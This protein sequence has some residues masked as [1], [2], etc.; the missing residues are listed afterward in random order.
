MEDEFGAFPAASCAAGD[1]A[2]RDFDAFAGGEAENAFGGRGG[3]CGEGAEKAVDLTGHGDSAGAFEGVYDAWGDAVGP[4]A[5]WQA[6][7]AEEHAACA[8]KACEPQLRGEELTSQQ[9]AVGPVAGEVGGGEVVNAGHES[10]NGVGQQAAPEPP[11]HAHAEWHPGAEGTP[12]HETPCSSQNE[13]SFCK[14]Q[15]SRTGENAGSL[16]GV[17]C[18]VAPPRWLDDTLP[19]ELVLQ[20]EEGIHAHGVLGE[21]GQAEECVAQVEHA[22]AEA[23]AGVPQLFDADLSTHAFWGGGAVGE[24]E[25]RQIGGGR[26]VLEDGDLDSVVHHHHL[27]SVVHSHLH[28]PA[29]GEAAVVQNALGAHEPV[30]EMSNAGGE[31]P[32]QCHAPGFGEPRAHGGEGGGGGEPEALCQCASVACVEG[33]DEEKRSSGPRVLHEPGNETGGFGDLFDDFAPKH[34]FPAHASSPL[35]VPPEAHARDVCAC[36]EQAEGVGVQ[37]RLASAET[38]T[39]TEAETETETET[40]TCFL[41]SAETETGGPPATQGDT[42]TGAGNDTFDAFGDDAFGDSDAL[43]THA[44][45]DME[46][47]YQAL[48]HTSHTRH[49]LGNTDDA[50]AHVGDVFGGTGDGFA[51]PRLASQ[52]GN[53]VLA[54]THDVLALAADAFGDVK[55]VNGHHV[56]AVNAL[57]HTHDTHDTH[58]GFGAGADAFDECEDAFGQDWEA[59]DGCEEKPAEE[60]APADADFGAVGADDNWG[61]DDWG[62][63]SGGGAA[64]GGGGVGGDVSAGRCAAPA[65]LQGLLAHWAPSASA[66][67]GA[68]ERARKWREKWG[69]EETQAPSAGTPAQVRT[70]SA[71]VAWATGGARSGAVVNEAAASVEA[72]EFEDD[73]F[74][75]FEEPQSLGAGPSAPPFLSSS[76]VGLIYMP[77]STPPLTSSSVSLISIVLSVCLGCAYARAVCVVPR[78][79]GACARKRPAGECGRET[80]VGERR[81]TGTGK[82]SRALSG[83]GGHR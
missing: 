10:S 78:A 76:S 13:A 79:N 35:M 19:R 56:N 27:V 14:E 33:A 80:S 7:V 48:E 43:H 26:G 23:G 5:S 38:E 70:G 22:S 3:E 53:H 32:A 66:S 28:A 20:Q 54:H 39:E 36:A 59:G 44:F 31:G 50:F 25:E 63:A 15:A 49:V 4:F 9:R 55:D 16:D 77:H 46:A 73:E 74:G 29:V 47:T 65:S 72:H 17:S 82:S 58:D 83:A 34:P 11:A 45:G 64:Y 75:D 24:E 69:L 12:A 41:A 21:D 71:D 42:H 8:G 51:H 57:A 60:G 18:A 37:C 6:A 52:D 62:Q 67:S 61:H 40:E 68:A 30:E 1:D 81:A 2:F